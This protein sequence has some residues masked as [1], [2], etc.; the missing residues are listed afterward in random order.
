MNTTAGLE[1]THRDDKARAQGGC[2]RST[3]LGIV[4]PKPS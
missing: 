4:A 2:H 3:E 1:T